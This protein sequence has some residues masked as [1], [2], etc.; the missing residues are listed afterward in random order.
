LE[1][2]SAASKAVV[3][4]DYVYVGERDAVV[5]D[6]IARAKAEGLCPYAAWTD[7]ELDRVVVFAGQGG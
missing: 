6:F 1:R 2:V 7:R 3:V 4:V 5:D